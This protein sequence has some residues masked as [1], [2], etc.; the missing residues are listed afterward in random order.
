MTMFLAWAFIGVFLIGLAG[1]VAGLLLMVWDFFE[2][3][4]VRLRTFLINISEVK[5]E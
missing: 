4:V 5:P 2:G 3:H 1:V